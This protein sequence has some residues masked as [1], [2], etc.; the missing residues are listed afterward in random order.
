MINTI[1]ALII[2]T[3]FCLLRLV[4]NIA[5]SF[6]DHYLAQQTTYLSVTDAR[7]TGCS[8]LEKKQ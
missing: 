3:H 8:A 1:L 7:I 2:V 4:Y 6:I 5:S